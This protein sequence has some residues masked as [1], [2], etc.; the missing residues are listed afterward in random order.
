[1]IRFVIR[2]YVDS[3]FPFFPF[4]SLEITSRRD[5]YVRKRKS[6]IEKYFGTKRERERGRDAQFTA[7]RRCSRMNHA[8]YLS[9]CSSRIHLHPYAC[10][11]APRLVHR[12]SFPLSPAAIQI[13][14]MNE[15]QTLASLRS[16]Y[17]FPHV[18]RN[19]S[20]ARSWFRG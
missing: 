14:A 9:R 1:M 18:C 19:N 7:I 5:R 8:I 2:A 20:T 13:L 17:F 15:P 10:P 6:R 16:K 3:L 11:C 12:S 4:F